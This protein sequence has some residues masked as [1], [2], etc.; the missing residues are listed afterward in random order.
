MLAAG[1]GFVV[2]VY[3]LALDAE[4]RL[5]AFLQA[6]KPTI[7]FIETN[8]G[9]WPRSWDDLALIAPSNDYDW[10]E[11]HVEYD[12]DA[13]PE[14]LAKLTPDNFNAIKN[15]RSCYNFELEVQVLIDTFKKYHS[16]P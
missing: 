9:A 11:Q 7:E 3:R 1:V 14:E 8:N 13:N 2:S 15:K 6:Y 12:F 10:V 5:Q 4:D 16:Q